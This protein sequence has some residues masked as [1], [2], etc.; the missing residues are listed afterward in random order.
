MLQLKQ[1]SR[2]LT[3]ALT[4]IPSHN[5]HTLSSTTLAT[6]PLSLSL[7]SPSG[8]PLTTVLNTILLTEIGLSPDNLKIY[9]LVGFN[10]I[11]NDSWGLLEVEKGL[12]LV[13]R[14]LDIENG[15][16]K[17][18]TTASE[19]NHLYVILFYNEQFP[20]AIAKL[21]LDNVSE[22]LNAGLKGYRG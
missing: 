8:I 12:K 13:I 10:H 2:L 20:D 16:H 22:I 9:S 3:Q 17:D 4:P 1:I 15:D 11:Q 14:R 21:K 19:G 7:L 6:S 5:S 18:D